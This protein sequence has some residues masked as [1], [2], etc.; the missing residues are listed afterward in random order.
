MAD[1]GNWCLIESDPGKSNEYSLRRT[2]SN[3]AKV[4]LP[5]SFQTWAVEVYK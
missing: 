4:F 3:S 2:I 1:E 5:N